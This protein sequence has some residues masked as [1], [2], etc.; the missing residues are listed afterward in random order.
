MNSSLKTRDRKVQKHD[1]LVPLLIDSESS[2]TKETENLNV[3]PVVNF[4]VTY[5]SSWT[6][7]LGYTLHQIFQIS[8][9]QSLQLIWVLLSK[10][11]VSIWCLKLS[12]TLAKD[13][14]KCIEKTSQYLQTINSSSE[15]H[16]NL[17]N[18][19]S[20]AIKNLYTFFSSQPL[21]R[22]LLMDFLKPIHF[23]YLKAETGCLKGII[24]MPVD[25]LNQNEN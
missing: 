18:S 9:Y 19:L 4:K 11:L 22:R 20:Q 6:Q 24:V 12:H 5:I 14:V 25:M 16:S 15:S 13:E 7:V 21:F 2:L 23:L 8:K 10:C 1:R 17:L 3:V